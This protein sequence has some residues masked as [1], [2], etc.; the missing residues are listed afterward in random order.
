MLREYCIGELTEGESIVRLK[1]CHIA[2]HSRGD[3]STRFGRAVRAG[4]DV[5]LEQLC[6]LSLAKK[7]CSVTLIRDA[8]IRATKEGPAWIVRINIEGLLN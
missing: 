1:Q 8:S 7:H 3:T 2:I 6:I 4:L 5:G